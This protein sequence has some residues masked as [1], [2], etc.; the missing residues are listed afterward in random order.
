M[1]S[2]LM[3]VGCINQEPMDDNRDNVIEPANID[4][5]SWK[6]EYFEE[7]YVI[8]EYQLNSYS[9]VI[10]VEIE[11]P[12]PCADWATSS[13]EK[14]GF[15]ITYTNPCLRFNGEPY[16]LID[17]YMVRVLDFLSK[18]YTYDEQDEVALQYSGV[19]VE[20]TE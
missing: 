2:L 16:I 10:P 18:Y 7:T 12:R 3:C 5:F 13:F 20:E 11:T 14:D 4:D 15:M 19:T 6:T 8:T 1:I 17:N 9:I